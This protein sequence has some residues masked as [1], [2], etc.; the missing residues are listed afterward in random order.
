M[1]SEID[2]ISPCPSFECFKEG[3]TRKIHWIDSKCK[4]YYK[5]TSSGKLKCNGYNCYNNYEIDILCVKFKC[6]SHEIQRGA[7][8]P[9]CYFR[10]LSCAV[11]FAATKALSTNEEACGFLNKFVDSL[12]EQS[13]KYHISLW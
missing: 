1:A 10:G 8:D 12:R 3:N 9:N 4:H 7:W 11:D 5:L 2:F 6:A 13:K